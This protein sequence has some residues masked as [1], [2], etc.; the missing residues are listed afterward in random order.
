MAIVAHLDYKDVHLVDW[1]HPVNKFR[2]KGTAYHVVGTWFPGPVFGDGNRRYVFVAY[3]D[4]TNALSIDKLKPSE[5]FAT[6]QDFQ[7]ARKTQDI[8]A[9]QTLQNLASFR[10][11]RTRRFLRY[12]SPLR[13]S[14]SCR[15]YTFLL[16]RAHVAPHC[17]RKTN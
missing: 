16:A 7:A 3:T 1:Q 12:S 15:Q 6:I 14:N 13:M 8:Q 4:P 2:P 9:R 5:P 10:H 11:C 17:D